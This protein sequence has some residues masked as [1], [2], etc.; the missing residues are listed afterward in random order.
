MI[1]REFLVMRKAV[2]WFVGCT[3]ALML[4]FVVFQLSQ[5][6]GHLE[7]DLNELHVPVAW[8]VTIFAAIF[9]VA[10][11][12]ASRG[13]ARVLWVLPTQRWLLALQMFAVDAV[14]IVAAYAGVFAGAIL[15]FLIMGLFE[16]TRI[17]HSIDWAGIAQSLLFVYAV[18][19][20]SALL[21]MAGR[22][23]AYCGLASLPL[24]LFWQMFANTRSTLGALLRAPAATNPYITYG[25]SFSF[26]AERQL[27]MIHAD[28]TQ[29]PLLLSLLWM[30]NRWETPVL[31]M[32]ALLTCAI[33]VFLWQ[34]AEVLNA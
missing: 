12:N 4:I 1:Y 9:G 8:V 29:N 24:L 25:V 17:R 30:G 20:W 16:P 11:G 7:T 14:G 19:G 6:R 13:P 10:L 34:R 27:A 32:T 3:T 33:A 21:G 15:F 28:A 22:R 18:Y 23:V 26:Q 5:F 31:A 2:L